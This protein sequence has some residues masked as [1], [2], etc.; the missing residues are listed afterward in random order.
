M[1]EQKP[2]RKVVGR[3]VAIALGAICIILAVCL[4]G[5]VADYTSIIGGKDNTIKTDN[6]Q[7]QTLTN[8][9]NQYK[10]WLNGNETLLNQTESWLNANVTLYN[11]YVA[12]H[13][14]SDSDYNSLTKQITNLTNIVDLA[15]STVWVNK[16]TVHQAA[17][18]YTLWTFSASYAAYISV[19]VTFSTTTNTYVYVYWTGLGVTYS[20]MIVVGTNGTAVFPVLPTSLI[21]ITVGNSNL[22]NEA[23]ETVTITYYY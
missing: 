8:Q 9:K 23:V 15:N 2:E 12:N 6:A 19:N 3:T 20:S 7:I 13:H 5:A 11:N 18:A 14:H 17:S 4:V 21:H 10:T 22:T 1:S 16:V